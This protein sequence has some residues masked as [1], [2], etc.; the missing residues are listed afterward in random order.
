MAAQAGRDDAYALSSAG[1][2]LA[3]VHR[4]LDAGTELIERALAV[5]PNLSGPLIQCGFVRAWLGQPDIAI[6]HLE[7]AMR[8]SPVDP[9]MFMIREIS[10]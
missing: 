9:F 5:N 6:E 8:L 2:A 3:S 10:G 1:F 4:D 7:R